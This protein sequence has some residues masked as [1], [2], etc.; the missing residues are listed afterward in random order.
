VFN[1]WLLRGE[2][3]DL[4]ARLLCLYALVGAAIVLGV[5]ILIGKYI[6]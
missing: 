2:L 5:G 4:F 3:G 1:K 6:L